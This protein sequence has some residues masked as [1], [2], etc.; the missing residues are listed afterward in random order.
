LSSTARSSG[1]SSCSSRPSSRNNNKKL[2]SAENLFF[3]KY[4]PPPYTSPAPRWGRGRMR[5]LGNISTK[6]FTLRL[7][8]GNTAKTHTGMPQRRGRSLHSP[9]GPS[10]FEE[11][12]EFFKDPESVVVDIKCF[13]EQK[14]LSTFF[15]LKLQPELIGFANFHENGIL[16]AIITSVRMPA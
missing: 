13:L 4:Q 2:C 7:S 12:E 3:F 16:S 14:N 11:P 6:K 15:Y 5:C 9:S 1:R 8:T 10:R